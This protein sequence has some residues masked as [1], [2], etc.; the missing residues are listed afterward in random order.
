MHAVAPKKG[1]PTI[2]TLVHLL[3]RDGVQFCSGLVDLVICV[4]RHGGGG[5]GLTLAGEGF[6]D[7]VAEDIAKVGGRGV[8]FKGVHASAR[9]LTTANPAMV[10]AD[11]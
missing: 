2:E 11:S 7:L 9:G 8:D 3:F 6:I 1:K 10:A 5:H 4:G